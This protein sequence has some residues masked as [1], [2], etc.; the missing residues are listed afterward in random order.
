MTFVRL[1]MITSWQIRRH[2]TV[3]LDTKRQ[4]PM[5]VTN[6]NLKFTEYYLMR[7]MEQMLGLDVSFT[8]TSQ[9]ICLKRLLFLTWK[10]QIRQKRRYRIYTKHSL[11]QRS[12]QAMYV[13]FVMEI[14]EKGEYIVNMRTS[15]REKVTVLSQKFN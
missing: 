6:Y 10:R 1:V 14:I 8:L 12:H 9:R 15:V 7:H 13:G 2:T 5:R 3:D 4:H 11:T